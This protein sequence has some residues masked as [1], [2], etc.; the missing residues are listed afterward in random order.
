MSFKDNIG[1]ALSCTAN[2]Y[3]TPNRCHIVGGIMCTLLL[4]ATLWVVQNKDAFAHDDRFS[5]LE[6]RSAK[7]LL[8]NEKSV[9]GKNATEFLLMRKNQKRRDMVM[10]W[11]R[12][13]FEWKQW[14]QK[15]QILGEGF[16]L[17][18]DSITKEGEHQGQRVAAISVMCS[19]EGDFTNLCR[20]IDALQRDPHYVW[21]DAVRLYRN[22]PRDDYECSAKISIRIPIFKPGTVA[23]RLDAME[24]PDAA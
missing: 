21:C 5:S 11:V 4:L 15:V 2:L 3:S 16:D 17:D 9:R 7:L 8:Q 18:F 20:F 14:S 22:S 1:K 13:D 6:I 10:N 12:K 23:G 19:V 24:I